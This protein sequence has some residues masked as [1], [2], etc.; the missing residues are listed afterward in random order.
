M[1]V[2]SRHK[3]LDQTTCTSE[4]LADILLLLASGDIGDRRLRLEKKVLRVL[5]SVLKKVVFTS[6]RARLRDLSVM[7]SNHT[8]LLNVLK[9]SQS[10]A[11]SDVERK[12]WF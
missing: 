1:K 7:R 5:V 6:L 10:I 4:P 3:P 2:T 11:T 9:Q 12:S 8:Q